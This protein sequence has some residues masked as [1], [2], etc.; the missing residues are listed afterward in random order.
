MILRLGLLLFPF[1]IWLCINNPFFRGEIFTSGDNGYYFNW[2]HYHFQSMLTGVFPLWN[3][4]QSWGMVEGF[5]VRAM[6]EFNPIFWLIPVLSVL[7][8]KAYLA[9]LLTVVLYFLLGCIG[10]YVLACYLLEDRRL[11]YLAYV[12]LMFSNL[13]IVLFEQ[14]VIVAI[15]VPTV[16]FFAFLVGFIR[17]QVHEGRIKYAVG[18]SYCLMLLVTTYIPFYF[19]TLMLSCF[20][21]CALL[22][23][24]LIVDIIKAIFQFCRKFPWISLLCVLVILLSTLPSLLGY[25]ES[26]SGQFI[27]ATNRAVQG[28]SN[29]LM[30][31]SETVNLGGLFT[32]F[33][34]EEF[35]VDFETALNYRVYLPFFIFILFLISVFNR[36]SRSQLVLFIAGLMLFL[37]A[38]ADVTPAQ[39][40]LYNHF[41]IFKTF[42]NY[43][44]FWQLLTAI[45]I[46]FLI[47]E[48]KSFLLWNSP[49]RSSKA[50]RV[51]LVLLVH[52]L[53]AVLL[54]NLGNVP[55]SSFITVGLSAILFCI[56]SVGLMCGHKGLFIGGLVLLALIQPAYVL[57]LYQRVSL[58]KAP[59]D[60][61]GKLEFL[62]VRPSLG[63]G[64]NEESGYFDR[65]KLFKDDSG[66]VK[67]DFIGTR[68]SYDLQHNIPW[69]SLQDY[70]RYKFIVYD[71]T[72]YI[73]DENVAWND[74][75]MSLKTF[76]NLA[77]VY[78]MKAVGESQASLAGAG[79]A[80][81]QVLD[82]AGSMF[83]VTSFDLNS[84][85]FNVNFNSRKFLVY[86]DSFHT[87]WRAFID[88]KSEPLYRANGAFKGLWVDSGKHQIR[89]LFSPQKQY[90]FIF[91]VGVFFMWGTWLMCLFFGRRRCL[92]VI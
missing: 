77:F 33:S 83:K 76:A 78:E 70:V 7:G 63:K 61:L 54:I 92:N 89:L 75:S 46:L 3:P 48:L 60:D 16:W 67:R 24:S 39:P 36:I 8:V 20:L 4:F 59:H 90:F 43:Y 5:D 84:V 50:V 57:P 9:T 40:F 32:Q 11:A 35:F 86:N 2:I 56:W 30:V 27:F 81:A 66:F 37:V 31:S 10:F 44:F 12:L 41:F 47:G 72:S 49:S 53:L 62:Y 26:Q 14:Y 42:R 34:W 79:P 73:N 68:H 51:A 85:S 71:K 58:D 91:L 69:E 87:G 65:V 29:P 55:V 74:L 25:L 17:E 21:A 19:L 22:R 80:P 88:G 28:S 15:F 64:I 45:I 1:I 52:A 82:G 18:I 13:G 38:A 6:G 23:F